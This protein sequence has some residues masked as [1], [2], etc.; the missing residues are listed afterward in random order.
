MPEFEAITPASHGGKTWRASPG[1]AFA[2]HDAVAALVMPEIPRACLYL[3][4][5]FAQVD[6]QYAPVAVQGLAPGQN[7]LVDAGGRW[8]ADYIPAAYRAYPFALAQAPDGQQVLCFDRAS[9]LLQD[10]PGGDGQSFFDADGQP[11]ERITQILQFL[12]QVQAG[13]AAT[14]QA[15]DALRQHG[16]IAPWPVRIQNDAGAQDVQ[17]LF[18]IDEQALNELPADALGA[19]RDAGALALAYCQLLSMQHLQRLGALAREHAIQQT[20]AAM[21]TPTGDLDLEFLNSGG[22]IKFH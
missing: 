5:A 21:R 15:C 9:G 8:R 22:T 17:G 14:R 13:R 20:S 3:P 18:R 11:A 16:L 19:V 12:T 2:A 7:L 10:G 4:L 1:Y 6:D